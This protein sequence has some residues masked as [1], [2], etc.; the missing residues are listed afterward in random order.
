MPLRTSW[1]VNRNEW[2]VRVRVLKPH[3]SRKGLSGK[4]K[5]KTGIGKSDLPGLQ[6]GPRKRDLVMSVDTVFASRLYPDHV[7][8]CERLGVQF[9]GPTRPGRESIRAGNG[10]RCHKN[11]ILMVVNGGKMRTKGE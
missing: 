2:G 11:V 4:A 10:T 5:A 7:R 6:R 9:P 3:T 8:I 1:K